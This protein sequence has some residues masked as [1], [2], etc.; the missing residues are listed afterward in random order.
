V[1]YIDFSWASVSVISAGTPS[2]V[3]W[4]MAR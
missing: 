4:E 2:S 3:A 1:S